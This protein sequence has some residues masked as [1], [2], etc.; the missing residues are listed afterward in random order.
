MLTWIPPKLLLFPMRN[1]SYNIVA[2]LWLWLTIL[3]FVGSEN[4]MSVLPQSIS[5]SQDD[6]ATPIGT[7]LLER[8]NYM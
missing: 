4:G 7:L 6:S 1:P 8:L 2:W 3:F 5:V